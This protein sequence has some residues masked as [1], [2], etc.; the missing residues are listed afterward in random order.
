MTISLCVLESCEEPGSSGEGSSFP[1]VLYLN[2]FERVLMS[3][4]PFRV[5]TSRVSFSHTV[6][7]PLFQQ[8]PSL[9]KTPTNAKVSSPNSC[10]T[11]SSESSLLSLFPPFCWHNSFSG[12]TVD[13]HQKRIRCRVI[14]SR[15]RPWLWRNK[16]LSALPVILSPLPK[17]SCELLDCSRLQQTSTTLWPSYEQSVSVWLISF[18][19][20]IIYW[21]ILR[22]S[23]WNWVPDMKYRNT[24]RLVSDDHD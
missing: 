8:K 14:Q 12:M 6:L 18:T 19:I 9:T 1:F 13:C 4:L 23:S 20:T 22:V 5:V 10:P 7:E 15:S 2:Y 3:V 16:Q 17:W 21:R 11:L 24:Y